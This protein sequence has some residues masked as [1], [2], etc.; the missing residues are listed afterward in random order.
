MR[1]LAG[2]DEAGL[3][4]FLGPLVTAAAA[5]ATPA[6]WTPEDPW[7]RLEAVCSD[8]WRRRETRLAVA[9]SKALYRG[10][11]V[12]ALESA[13]GAFS[14]LANAD[15]RPPLATPG[16]A[17]GPVHPCY[18]RRL[19]PFPAHVD[20]AG[21]AVAAEALGAALARAGASCAHLE[22]AAVYEPVLN[23]RFAAGL[24]KNQALLAETGRHLVRLAEKFPHRPILAVVDKQGGRDDYL[25][26]LT[27]LFP[28]AWLETLAKGRERSVYRWR[29]AGGEVEFRFQV[30]ADAGSFVTAL[31][32]MAAK[33]AR[34]R[35]MAELNAWFGERLPG[36]APTAGYPADARRWLDRAG[37]VPG[38]DLE[39]V[40]RLR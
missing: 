39:L 7:R 40:R 15:P 30:K 21:L 23:R 4:P 35:A 8:R 29:R 9:D 34:E 18:S 37:A 2:V 12:A 6:D 24:N 26:F 31:A 38:L 28:G 17:D 14:L 32:S 3:G 16:A 20:A 19:D 27:S 22:V 33:Y 11:G 25:P 1:I 13:V 5:L 10:G 36:L